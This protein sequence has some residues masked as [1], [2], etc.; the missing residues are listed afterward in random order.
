MLANL[1]LGV[2]RRKTGELQLACD[3]RFTEAHAQM[4][5]LHLDAHD[6]LT[7]KIAEL[8]QLVAAANAQVK[9]Q[10]LAG[11]L[12]RVCRLNFRRSAGTAAADRAH[13]QQ[14]RSGP[15]DRPCRQQAD[16]DP[17]QVRIPGS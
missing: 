7:T 8:D 15:E 3:G 13:D 1:A 12:L 9:R 6:H 11:S 17:Q 16:G 2:L 4:C 5:R 10:A 14:R